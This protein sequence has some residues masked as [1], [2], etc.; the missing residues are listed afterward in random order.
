VALEGRPARLAGVRLRSGRLLAADFAFFSIA[1]E[2]RLRLARQLRCELTADGCLRVDCDGR[3]SVEGVYAAGDVTPGVQLVAVDVG[4]GAAAGV[5]CAR[6]LHG[7]PGTLSSSNP[8]PA[9]VADG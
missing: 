4:E 1:H 3:T 2:P 6:S 7:E 9:T 5:A 8:A